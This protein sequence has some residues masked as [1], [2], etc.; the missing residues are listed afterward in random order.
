MYILDNTGHKA[1]LF[2]L[3]QTMKRRLL[4][5]VQHRFLTY[6]ANEFTN[7]KNRLP[8]VLN[9]ESFETINPYK[10]KLNHIELKTDNRKA[11]IELNNSR[12]GYRFGHRG[13]NAAR[14]QQLGP[15][16]GEP[17]GQ[18]YRASAADRSR[19]SRRSLKKRPKSCEKKRRPR[20]WK[21]LC[22]HPRAP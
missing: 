18:R 3:L 13:S 17:G 15:H 22:G 12:A 5:T 11:K 6:T 9:L 19:T 2:W 8:E 21:L 10:S 14:R 4:K 16:D 1:Q 20:R 7:L